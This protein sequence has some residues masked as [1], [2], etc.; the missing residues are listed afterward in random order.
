[1]LVK[2]LN[3]L[4]PDKKM[5]F[6]RRNKRNLKIIEDNLRNAKKPPEWMQEILFSANDDKGSGRITA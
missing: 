6:K 3:R 5:K 4:T 2:N 1:M